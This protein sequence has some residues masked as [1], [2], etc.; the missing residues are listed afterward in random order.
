MKVAYTTAVENNGEPGRII[1][2]DKPMV[3]LTFDDGPDA[4]DTPIILDI[5]EANN[6]VATF[7]ILGM[8]AEKNPEVLNRILEG[9]NE[10][11]NHSFNH[12]S[13]LRLSDRDLFDQLN[14]TQYIVTEAT[15]GYTPPFARPPY[16]FLND[17][18]VEKIPMPI[19]MWSLDTLDWENKD[20]G[21]VYD[22]VF[23]DV[24]DGDIILMHDIFASTTEAVKLVVPELIRR[25]YQLVTVSE[26]AEHRGVTLQQGNVYHNF[27][28]Q[29]T[30]ASRYKEKL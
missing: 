22:N 7:F 27:Y 21:T 29:E 4:V 1:D 10:I 12:Q 28:P 17:A 14:T 18:L 25:G 15:G 30:P 26:L 13:Y 20:A 11:G 16:G 2:P 24:K 9:G 3:A 19:I 8:E 6:A 5:L 23:K